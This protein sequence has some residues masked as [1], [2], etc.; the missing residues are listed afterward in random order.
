MAA[1]TGAGGRWERRAK[2]PLA[3]RLGA[4]VRRRRERRGL[5]Q[6][7]LAAALGRDR[8]TVSRWEAGERLPTVPALLALARALGCEPGALLGQSAAGGR[9]A[10]G[11][12]G[13]GG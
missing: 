13:E 6:A 10:R 7:G 2:T 11:A 8:S 3:V 5:S 4:N 1:A 12:H 9:T